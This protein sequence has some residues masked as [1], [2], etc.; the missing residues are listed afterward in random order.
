MS[1]YAQ[2][3][4]SI[5]AAAILEQPAAYDIAMAA[6]PPPQQGHQ[7]PEIK[8]DSTKQCKRCGEKKA[9]A[10]FYK[11]KGYLMGD[12]KK[13]FNQKSY[14][15]IRAAQTAAGNAKPRGFAGLPPE[16]Q[17]QIYADVTAG[18]QLS[19]ISREQNVGL[20]SLRKWKSMGRIVAPAPAQ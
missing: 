20:D 15:R 4:R 3:A 5:L 7:I 17:A 9:V 11:A 8:D 10:D 13:C 1:L 12:C 18:K 19:I 16:K 6:E 14:A 2:L